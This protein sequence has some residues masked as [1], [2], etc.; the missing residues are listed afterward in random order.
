MFQL[1][2]AERLIKKHEGLKLKPYKCTSGK[3]T[4]GYG[5]NL[6]NRGLTEKECV[7]LLHND[8]VYLNETLPKKI[9]FWDSLSDIRKAVLIDMAYNLG[10]NGLLNFKKMLLALSLE[11]YEKASQEMLKSQWALQVKTR[12]AELAI[13]M[14]NNK[15]SELE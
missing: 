5:R 14:L 15:I 1:K 13:T 7:Y 12:A 8:L 11:E 6:E 4:I 2:I 3:L 9:S 10:V